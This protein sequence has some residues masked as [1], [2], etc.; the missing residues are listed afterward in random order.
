MNKR[1]KFLL[2]LV[3]LVCT[4]W[5]V[6]ALKRRQRRIL[7]NVQPAL[8]KHAYIKESHRTE[9]WIAQ[10]RRGQ[11][12][13]D[14]ARRAVFHAESVPKTEGES[15]RKRS[16]RAL[17]ELIK[18]EHMAISALDSAL[19]EVD[20]RTVAWQYRKFR[21]SHGKQAAALSDRFEELGG[22]PIEYEVGSGKGHA[23]LF[24]K[25]TSMRDDIS[26]AGMRLGA[27]RGIKRYI[28]NIDDVDDAK[29]L[30]IIR[31]NLESKQDEMRWYDDQ[32]AKE[33]VET[34]ESKS[35]EDR[36]FFHDIP[37]AAMAIRPGIALRLRVY[38]EV[39]RDVLLRRSDELPPNQAVTSHYLEDEPRYNG[40]DGTLVPGIGY[41]PPLP[42]P[43]GDLVELDEEVPAQ[44]PRYADATFYEEVSRRDLPPE[45]WS[46]EV[47]LGGNQTLMVDRWYGLEI[48]IREV[49]IGLPT[50]EVMEPIPR[51]PAEQHVLLHVTAES[52]GTRQMPH[53]E[54][55]HRIQT[56]TLPPTGNSVNNARFF[57]RP[58]YITNK[59]GE[60]AS[61]TIRLYYEFN[62]IEVIRVKAEVR[63]RG[64]AWA[65]G[66]GP[67]SKHGLEQPIVVQ[68]LRQE[69]DYAIDPINVRPRSMHIDVTPEDQGYSFKFTFR[70]DNSREVVF[71]GSSAL[72]SKA[73][74]SAISE[75]RTALLDVVMFI[76]DF[77]AGQTERP[78]NDEQAV[79]K[80][81]HLAWTGRKLW[82][83]IFES[84]PEGGDLWNIGVWLR[85]HPLQDGGIIQV[86]VDRGATSFVFPWNLVYDGDLEDLNDALGRPQLPEPDRFWNHFWGLHYVIEQRISEWHTTLG[87]HSAC[88]DANG[89]EIGFLTW[90]FADSAEQ[91][92]MIK[93][94]VAR[95]KGRI[96]TGSAITL[97]SKAYELLAN[98]TSQVL[99]FYT[100]G[101][102]SPEDAGVGGFSILKFFE[103]IPADFRE[104]G[105][106]LKPMLEAMRKPD[107]EVD[108][109]WINLKGGKVY[110]DQL[111]TAGA[112]RLHNRP[113][114]F[115]NMCESAQVVPSISRSF[116]S[117]FLQ[118]NARCVIGTEC[119]MKTKFGHPFSVELFEQ[120]LTG[121]EIGQ[122]L[123]NSRR[124][125]ATVYNNPSGLAYNLFGSATARLDLPPAQVP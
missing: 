125:F 112:V 117:L 111:Y 53:F 99:Y 36:D 1:A 80:L 16:L 103:K 32:A 86:S 97:P 81:R 4:S 74:E 123:L 15:G 30:G 87:K 17:E 25:L 55:R 121:E 40:E 26:L 10:S 11:V 100:H 7:Q 116:I 23:G 19:E 59:P 118:R 39:L 50:D 68:Q 98:C 83:L 90:M 18:T 67:F 62:L 35:K 77:R 106:R 57:V 42:P 29:A 65:D 60:F 13:V 12:L 3:A 113:I 104:L 22:E 122:S 47:V 120:L 45:K 33:R 14:T 75:V 48:A 82:S 9:S 96:A 38:L 93:Q 92:Q 8:T 31:K 28:D 61:I 43:S 56:L 107:Y 63:S 69:S 102:I 58:V 41:P 37:V 72:S 64:D 66:Q 110:L 52:D 108:K 54:I 20:D 105:E 46:D 101:H 73:L 24:G 85:E 114:V 44:I 84:G 51:L 119:T 109:S 5:A 27:E 95:T 49:R 6:Y 91:E 71:V 89:P 79:L 94:M 34:A 76:N 2:V 88:S 124:K 70:N 115:L 21:D 78:L